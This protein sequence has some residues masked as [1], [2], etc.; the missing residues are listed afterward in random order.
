VSEDIRDEFLRI[1]N[2]FE[3]AKEFLKIGNW[4]EYEKGD[5]FLI[6]VIQYIK[7]LTTIYRLKYQK[8]M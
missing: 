2:S 6:K 3:V 1:N 5:D 7:C 4:K 8:E